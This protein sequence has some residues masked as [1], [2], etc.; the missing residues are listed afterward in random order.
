MNNTGSQ[1]HFLWADPFSF[2]IYKLHVLHHFFVQIV[3]PPFLLP[4]LVHP[5]AVVRPSYC[6]N[7]FHELR[8]GTRQCWHQGDCPTA[9]GSCNHG[10]VARSPLTEWLDSTIYRRTAAWNE[11]FPSYTVV[12]CLWLWSL[13]TPTFLW[14][15][16]SIRALKHS[17]GGVENWVPWERHL[18]ELLL[19]GDK[20]WLEV[21]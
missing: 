1:Q 3:F 7:I 8:R 15:Y 16:Y 4:D 17:P 10:Q 9:W 11:S 12:G 5:N 21:W 20:T 18:D 19:E 13:R 14:S 2:W 6:W